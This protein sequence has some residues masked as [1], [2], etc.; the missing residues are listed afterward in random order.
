MSTHAT[1]AISKGSTI[2]SIYVHCD[3]YPSYIVP[4]LLN[5]YNTT[6]QASQAYQN[7]LKSL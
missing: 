4:I 5:H 6:E 2:N 3:G 1:I 7:K